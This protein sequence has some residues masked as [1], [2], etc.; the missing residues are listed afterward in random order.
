MNR[1]LVLLLSGLLIAC[2]SGEPKPKD[3]LSKDQMAKVVAELCIYDQ[4]YNSD[5]NYDSYKVNA[6]ILKKNN[7]SLKQYKASFEYYLH[8]PDNIQEIYDKAQKILLKKA[9]KLE[10]VI[11]NR[12]KISQISNNE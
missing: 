8:D 12:N 7:I 10:N 6:S 1:I 3:L 5:M 4:R 2:N 9:P 11:K